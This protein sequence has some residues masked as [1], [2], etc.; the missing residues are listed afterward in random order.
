[1]YFNLHLEKRLAD[2]RIHDV[3]C[4]AKMDCLLRG[5]FKEAQ[6]LDWKFPVGVFLLPLMMIMLPF[7]IGALFIK[8]HWG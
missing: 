8:Q 5:Q 2:Q 6:S 3:L 1:M 7:R 4:L